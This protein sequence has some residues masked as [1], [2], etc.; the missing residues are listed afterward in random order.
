MT[1]GRVPVIRAAAGAADMDICRALFIEYQEAIGTDL[2]FQGFEEELQTLPGA[3]APPSGRL[4]LAVDGA[5]IA[6]SVALRPAGPGI[7]EMKRL[8]VR[9][10][11]RGSG[12]GRR[13]AETVIAE[14]RAIGYAAMRLDTLV[15]MA[16]ARALYVD[17]GFTEIPPYYHNPL[18]GVTFMELA[19]TA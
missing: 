2:C 9:P 10:P 5:A 6:G 12:L 16:A 19:L 18:G 11:W 14:G 1:K 17:L 3:Y 13:L 4:M 7:C 15:D 8:Y